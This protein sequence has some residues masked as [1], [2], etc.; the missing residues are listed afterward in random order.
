MATK[1][2]KVGGGKR[3]KGP[4]K[5][6]LTAIGLN[7]ASREA[8]V[9]I[10]GEENGNLTL[11]RRLARTLVKTG[12]DEEAGIHVAHIVIGMVGGAVLVGGAIA[13]KRSLSQ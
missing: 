12:I 2:H 9:A 5:P 8:G 7:H 10:F 11:S 4:K 13:V 3:K 6:W 1:R